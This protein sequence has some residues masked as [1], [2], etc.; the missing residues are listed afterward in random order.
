MAQD[1]N[2]IT[3]K[4]YFFKVEHFAEIKES[5]AG[6]CERIQ[7]LSFDDRG[8]YLFDI[9]SKARYSVYPDT[10][11]FPI[12][13]RFGKIRRDALPQIE[14]EGSLETLE[15]QENAGLVDISH[16]VIFEDG[17]VAAE[18][19]SDGPKLAKLTPYFLEKG[20]LNTPPVFLTLLERDIVEIVSALDSVRVLEVELPPDAAEVAKQADRSF[21]DAIKAMESLGATKRVGL[22]L[23]ADQGTLKLKKLAR[24]LAELIKSNPHERDRFNSIHASGYETDSRSARYID[25]LESKMMTAEYFTRTSARSRSIESNDAYRVLERAYLKNS[26]RLNIAATSKDL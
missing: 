18:W 21:Y 11:Q 14:H 19:N 10:L 3:R 17:F 7:G 15:L 2:V 16:I 6:A 1:K 12:R 25:I 26:P 5:L 8:R 9:T 4:I 23:T 24:N 22:K 20:R 13:L